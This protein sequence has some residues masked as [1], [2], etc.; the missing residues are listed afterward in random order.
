MPGLPQSTW[1]P[2]ATLANYRELS[3]GPY[4]FPLSFQESSRVI[5]LALDKRKIQFGM[6]DY[7]EPN[8]MP[9]GR[10]ITI[11]GTVGSGM[12]GTAGNVLATDVDLE[13]ERAALAGM[14]IL[15]LQKLF[16]R[17]DRYILAFLETF[18]FSFQQDGGAFRYADYKLTFYAPDPRYYSVNATTATIG[19]ITDAAAHN[20]TIAHVGNVRAFPTFVFTGVCTAPAIQ[21]AQGAAYISVKFS[22]LTMVAGDKLSIATDPRPE[23][24]NNGIIYTPSGGAAVNALKYASINDFSNNLDFSQFFPFIESSQ[25]Y[26]PAQTFTFSNSNATANYTVNTAWNDTWL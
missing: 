5:S 8:S 13:N 10:V 4:T 26:T 15:G 19:P 14:Q 22:A 25:V 23:Y 24:R 18:E 17:Y 20:S 21:I 1:T 9:Q 12:V 3:F 2:G 16:V 7:V 6:G 11:V